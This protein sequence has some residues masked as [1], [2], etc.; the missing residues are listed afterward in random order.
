[1]QAN[2]LIIEALATNRIQLKSQLERAFY[3]VDSATSASEAL[4]Q[5]ARSRPNLII[6]S[7]N[8]SDVEP[9]ALCQTIKK[10]PKT[11]P[12]PL[13]IMSTSGKITTIDALQAG[14]DDLVR[15]PYNQGVLMARLRSLLRASDAQHE[16]NLRESADRIIG[17]S[18][19][20]AVFLSSALVTV[21]TAHPQIKNP[22]LVLLAEKSEHK[23]RFCSP[24][25]N[26]NFMGQVSQSDLVV[27][28][29]EGDGTDEMLRCIADIRAHHNMRDVGVIVMG[30]AGEHVAQRALD[31]GANDLI[32]PPFNIE[33]V[34]LRLKL[35][36][37]RKSTSDKLKRS[38][39]MGMQAAMIDP[40][41]E[42]SNRRCALPQMA[43]IV[44]SAF[45]TGENCAIVLLDIDYFR[46]V[47]NKY[48][49]VVGDTVLSELAQLLRKQT[50]SRDVV[51]R[52]GGE[53][54]LIVL[55]QTP[56]REAEKWA[57][58]LCDVISNTPF[59]GS[60][61]QDKIFITVS[62]G[63]AHVPS[64]QFPAPPKNMDE[65][66]AVV[67]HALYQSKSQGRNQLS[68]AS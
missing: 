6:L 48:G 42:V 21:V 28:Q 52:M 45:K 46:E 43:S 64:P 56:A 27:I 10:L 18:E 65:M 26:P 51:A 68:I 11:R 2:I 66:I 60:P 16:L 47:N 62:L 24:V 35:Q 5:I 53:E 61:M 49:H 41:T 22:F 8:I 55:P 44:E 37:N 23:F 7:D 33:E 4:Q 12:V 36:L 38:V 54:F 34:E 57:Q 19:A 67:D 31:F 58:N 20:P 63:L 15:R 30:L 40:L 59:S 50:S 9:L 3:S 25:D 17:A 39:E 14:A 13:I 29:F 1:M 32:L